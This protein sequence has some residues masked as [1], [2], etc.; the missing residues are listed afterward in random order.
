M[1]TAKPRLW[2]LGDSIRMSYQPI[3]ARLLGERAEVVGPEEN[4][5]FA[6]YTLSS[7]D[8]WLGVLGKPDVVHWNNGLHDAG[9]N[10]SRSPHQLPVADYAKNLECILDRLQAMT[11]RV[12]WATS[13]P[14]GIERPFSDTAWSWKQGDPERYNDAAMSVMKKR[15]IPVN[16]L[17]AIIAADLSA[18]LV[19]DRVHLTP[20]GQEKCAAAVVHAVTPL[21]AGAG[22]SG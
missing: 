10:P 6:L 5:Q 15:N 22:V 20:A 17:H 19:E 7:L 14:V 3:V 13:T 2:L 9:F 12:V 11:R 18:Y 1:N 16:D 4:C 8:R 21:L